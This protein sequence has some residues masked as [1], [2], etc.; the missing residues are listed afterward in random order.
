M[1]LPVCLVTKNIKNRL[2]S[3]TQRPLVTSCIYHS[4]YSNCRVITKILKGVLLYRKK[5]KHIV[6]IGWHVQQQGFKNAQLNQRFLLQ[7]F[8]KPVAKPIL[9]AILSIETQFFQLGVIILPLAQHE[10][11]KPCLHVNDTSDLSVAC[12][13][14]HC[15]AVVLPQQPVD[16]FILV[17]ARLSLHV[18]LQNSG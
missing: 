17:T 5:L 7:M 11:V 1:T 8:T 6:V 12:V 15:K 3:C 9:W 4:F 2:N 10:K 16:L 13:N 14:S 18:L